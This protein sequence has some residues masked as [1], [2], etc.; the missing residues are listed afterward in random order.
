M[1]SKTWSFY[2]GIALQAKPTVKDTYTILKDH[3]F[4]DVKSFL[5]NREGFTTEQTEE[6]QE[7][8]IRFISIC[9]EYTTKKTPIIISSQVDPFWHTHILFTEDYRGMCQK[10][11]A[12]KSAYLNHEPTKSKDDIQKLDSLYN[13]HTLS[14][15]K[16]HF[17]TPPKNFWPKD[18][19]ICG[20]SSCACSGT[21]NE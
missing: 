18:A 19:M 21:G 2:Y 14:L 3:N 8:Y 10:I 4:D 9:A 20:G 16:K 5:V 15:Y 12:E 1:S 13:N 17:G 7:E 6:M 11:Y